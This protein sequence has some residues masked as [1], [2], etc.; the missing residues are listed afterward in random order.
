MNDKLKDLLWEI[1]K[2]ETDA[3]YRQKVIE[4]VEKEDAS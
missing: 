1:H 2:Q 4:K 3:N